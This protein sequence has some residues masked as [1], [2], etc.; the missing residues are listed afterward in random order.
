MLKWF[1]SEDGGPGSGDPGSQVGGGGGEATLAEVAERLA[2]TEQLVAQLKEMIRE[3]DITLHTKDDQLKAEK[4]ACEA[5]LSKLRLQNKAKVTSLTSQLEELKKQQG[6]QGTPT[7]SKKGGADKATEGGEQASR[8]KIV[9]LKKKVEDLEQHLAQREKEL[10]N[11][12]R[13]VE[14]QR[15]RG[16]EMDSMLVEKDRKLSEKEAYIVHLQTALAG[17]QSVTPAPQQTVSPKTDEGGALEELQLLVQSLTRKVGE[18]EERYSLLQEQTDSLKELLSTEKHQY[19]QKENMYKQNIQT[20]KDII[21]QKDNKLMEVNQMHEQELFKLAAKSDASADLEQ[22]LKALKQKLHEKEEV[23][24]G[25]TQVIDVLQGEVDGRDQQIKEL[26]ERLRRLQVERESLESKLEAEKHVMRAQ[27]RDLLEKQQGEVRRMAEQH[28]SQMAQTRQELLGQLDELRR[29]T[30]ALPPVNQQAIGSADQATNLATVQRLAE[31]EVQAKQKTEEASKSE[32]KFLKMKAWSKSRIRQLEA[33]LRKSQAGGA[34]PDLIALQSRITELEEEREESLWKLEQYEELKA[35]NDVLEAKLVVYEEQQRTLQADLEQFTKRAASQASECGSAEDTQSQVLEWQEMVAE[36]VSARDQAREEKVAMEL[37]IGHMEEEREGLIED[38]WFFPGCSDPALASRQQ[39]LEEELAQ[40]QG[41]S[42]HRAKKQAVPAQRTLQEDFEFDEQPPF[43]DPC[44]A[45]ESTTPMEGENMGGWWPEY[46]TPDTGGLRSVV[47][48]LELERNQLQEQILVLEERC[49]D[50]EDRLQLQARI[51]ALQVTFDVDEVRRPYWVSQNESERLQ[52]QLTSL[53]S[54]QSR[55]AE[56]HQ[57]LVTSLN[58]QLKGLTDTQ[59]CLESSLIEKEN[60]LAKTSEKLELISNL[61]ETLNEKDVQY[62]DVSDKLLQAEHNLMEVSKK[63]GN[64]EKLCSELKAEVMDLT[65]KLNVLKEKTQKQEVI[66]ETLQ[67]DLDQTNDELDK[68]NTT[69]LEERAQLIH[70]LQ[71]CER[72]IDGLKD[73]LLDKEKEIATLSGNMAEYTEQITV[74]KQEIRLKEDDLV[75][76][77]SALSKVEREA[78]IIRD[79]QNSDQQVL[80]NKITELVEKLKDMETELCKAREERESKLV[81]VVHLTKQAEEDKKSIQDLEGEIQKQ[82]LSHHNHLSEC[83]THISSLKEQ[84]TFAIHKLQQESEGL[85]LELKDRNTRNENLQ[86]LLQDKEQSY[87]KELKSFKE[88]Q[89]RLLGEVTKYNHDVKSLNKQLEEQVQSRELIQKAMQEKQETIASLEDQLK[90]SEKAFEEERQKFSSELQARDSEYEKLGEELKTKSDNIEKVKNLLKNTR[91]EKRQLERNLKQL[92]EELETQKQNADQ[93]NEKV[94]ASLQLDRNLELQVSYLTKENERLQLEVTKSTKSISALT[95]EKEILHTKISVSEAQHSENSKVI[96]GLQREKEELNVR[97]EELHRVIEQSKQS[98]SETL[99]EKMNECS[100]LNQLLRDREEKEGQFQE[101][102]QSM[103]SQVDELQRNIEAKERI[104]IDLRAKMVAQESQQ[105]QFQE[106]LSLLQEQENALKSGLMEKNVM[107]TQKQE[108]YNALQNENEEHNDMIA[109][110]QA[111]AELLHGDCL[112]LHQ[113]IGEK[114]EMIKDVTQQCQKYKDQLNEKN[115]MVLSLSSQLSIIQNN[116]IKLESEKADMR[117]DLDS[118]ITENVKMKQELEQKQAELMTLHNQIQSLTEKNHQLGASHEIREKELAQQKKVGS[119]IDEKLKAALEQNISFS[120]KIESLTEYSQ[121]LEKDLNQKVQ[122]ISKLTSERNLLQEKF[123]QLEKQHSDDQEIIRGLLK[124]KEE[125][126]LAADELNK[127]L[128]LSKQSNSESLLEKTTEC[129]NLSKTLREREEQA[130][131]LHE[132]VDSLKMQVNELNILINEKEKT[133]SE[134]FAHK[135]AQQAQLVQLQDTLSLLQ[136]QGS[137]LKSVLMEKD[138]LLNQRAEDCSSYQNEVMLQ[139]DLISKM[140]GEAELLREENLELRR[141]VDDKEQNLRDIRL[142]F[143]N[144][145]EEL[146][147]RN[148]S[149]ISLS[150]QLGTMNENTAKMEVEISGLKSALEKLATEN[151]QLIQKV[152]QKKVEVVDLKDD[153]QVLK[154]QNMRIKSELEKSVMEQSKLLEE[155]AELK[156][157]VSNKDN[158]M[159]DLSEQLKAACLSKESL[160]LAVQEKEH[161]LKQQEMVVQQLQA[162]FLEVEGQTSQRQGVIMELQTKVQTLQKSLQDKDALLQQT[163]KELSFIQEKFTSE[164]QNFRSDLDSNSEIISGLQSELSNA[165][166]KNT[167]LSCKIDEQ[168]IQLKQNV[169]YNINVGTQVSEL[170]ESMVKLRGQNAIL[171]SECS[172]LKETLKQKEQFI[173]EFQNTS[174]ANIENLN[175]KLGS[176]EAECMSLKEQLSHLQESVTKLNNTFQENMSEVA[177]LKEALEEK[178]TTLLDRSKSLQEMQIKADEAVLFKAH[179]MESTE[180]ASQLQ[181]QIQSLSTESENLNRS[182]GEKQS[183]FSNLQ[184][185]YATHLEELQDV[186]KQLSESTDKVSHLTKL[187]SDG[188]SALQEAEDTIETLRN[189]LHLIQGELQKTQEVNSS[190]LKQK[191]EAFATHQTSMTSFTVEIERLKSQHLQVVAQMNVLTENLEQREMALHAINSQYT[192]QAKN[193][194]HLVSEMQK[195]EEQ[196]KRLN[197]EISLSKEEHSKQLN[198]VNNEKTNLQRELKRLGVEKDDLERRLDHQ[199]RATQ[200]ELHLQVQQQSSSMSEI[201]EKVMSEKESL[202]AEEIGQN[203]NELQKALQDAEAYRLQTEKK[204]SSYQEELADLRSDRNRL[205]SEALKMK[206]QVA[207]RKDGQPVKEAVALV[208][209]GGWEQIVNQLQTERIQM[210]R[211]LQQCLYEIQQ[212]DQHNQQLNTELRAVSQTLRDTQNRCFWLES[213]GQAMQGSACAEVAP[214]APQERSSHSVT[215]ETSEASQLQDRLFELEQSLRE[216]RTRR[217]VAEEALRVTEERAKS[218]SRSSQR[219]YSIQLETEEEWETVILNP[220]EPLLT[221]KVKGGMLMCRRWFR[222]RSLYCSKLITTRARSRYFFLAYLLT[223]HVLVLM[224]LTG[225]L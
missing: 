95:A 199:I 190:L 66:I 89:N 154:E 152:D 83:E 34:P 116:A 43:Q 14:T 47:D 139:K 3:K 151:R 106:K 222:G 127:V 104:I 69:H 211:D 55:D 32:A 159:S 1:S 130:A 186:R 189:E 78:K 6:S 94:T 76:L 26:T 85:S 206:E 201:V 72:E 118:S 128:E 137:V 46:S 158:K 144:H 20:F 143:H 120:L 102:V 221:R 25:K 96:E 97:T 179:F 111:E 218:P 52:A 187:L 174:S 160:C 75:R 217:E 62:K 101:K 195:L 145:K 93:L 60:T 122:S 81:E 194:A 209:Q 134:H 73:T 112:Q 165:A 170:K 79:S 149:V 110:Q 214:G 181:I 33:E 17:D 100:H 40:A 117:I 80:N 13:E 23:L 121:V 225:A 146:N 176:K 56:K 44:S 108:E 37:R 215:I 202:Q 135:E 147:K 16:E 84:M 223:L 142:N 105:V 63:C 28:Q 200:E 114:E 98:I 91:N 54:Q 213:Q 125:L 45:S 164:I 212:R 180:L 77:E 216:E 157:T 153:I 150:S 113:Q 168:E 126:T 183:A 57:L 31:L 166:K 58:E 169:D 131:T 61:R 219:D 197:E 88:E 82:A 67:A 68:L 156:K 140:G 65:Q 35:K 220:S 64:F 2:Q 193:T 207:E 12:R 172:T 42:Q 136:E 11:S 141:Q 132:Q 155:I 59:E 161:S 123:S 5:K 171:N 133:V 41:L 10:E 162:Q 50:L 48:E 192:A 22:L 53:R 196:N 21:L 208:G 203:S 119:D 38:D 74:L 99:L 30:V 167:E 184:E 15:Q 210:H 4:E 115:E 27:L 71:S 107:L 182:L 51:E 9:V 173:F 24:L 92:T 204:I 70:E 198:E 7:H 224:C 39:E 109:K 19:N 148:E 36:A 8:G 18:A 188:K 86:Q 177:N 124:N 185:K 90:A 205:L 163:E 178:E 87:E 129:H 49:H 175:S 103:M 29:V 138:T 191:E